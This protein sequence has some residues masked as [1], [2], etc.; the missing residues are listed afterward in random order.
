MIS[1]MFSM[2]TV[3]AFHSTINSGLNFRKFP[4][5]MEQHFLDFQK[6]KRTTSPG[7]PKFSKISY[8]EFPFH[9]TF[10]PEFPEFLFQWFAFGNSKFSRS[11]RNFFREFTYHSP[12]IRKFRN[13]W[14]N[15]K[16]A[17]YDTLIIF[18][19]KFIYI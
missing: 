16:S 7:I 4:G 8:R 6:I 13:F 15:A 9:L 18:L 5:L 11:S 19:K 14:L 10:L 17:L 1:E 12:W 2:L 3:G